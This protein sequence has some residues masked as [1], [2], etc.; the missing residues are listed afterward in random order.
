MWRGV[1]QTHGFPP[2]GIYLYKIRGQTPAGVTGTRIWQGQT[3]SYIASHT[4]QNVAVAPNPLHAGQGKHLTFYPKGLTVEIYDA[5]G[6]LIK[7]LNNASQWDCTNARGEMVCTGLY[8]FRATDGNGFQS[9]GKIFCG[10]IMK[11]CQLSVIS[12]QLK[13]NLMC[14][15]SLLLKTE[16][17]IPNTIIFFLLLLLTSCGDEGLVDPHGETT[18]PRTR[19]RR[20]P[21]HRFPNSYRLC[22]DLPQR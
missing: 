16:Y 10:E 17:R 3:F 15:R 12:C 2:T 20:L 21:S 9:T 4:H 19:Y 7:V 1:L 6:N 11:S 18:L 22:M 14:I 13:R 8:F 5:S